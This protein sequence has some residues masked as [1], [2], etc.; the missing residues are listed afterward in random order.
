[1]TILCVTGTGTD[2]GKTIATAAIAGLL[3][4]H[5][6]KVVVVKPAQT[7]YPGTG[8]GAGQGGDLDDVVRLT[9]V[10]GL[11]GFARYP[12]RWRRWRPRAGPGWRRSCLTTSP[13]GLRRSTGRIEPCS[14]K[15]PA[16]CS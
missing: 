2:V 9:G 11:H 14:S 4:S 10:T 15:E 3:R 13:P 12:G 7:G 1:M 5:G 8:E 6:E 16:V